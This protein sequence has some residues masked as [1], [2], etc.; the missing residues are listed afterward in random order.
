[1]NINLFR[2]LIPVPDIHEATS[3]YQKLFRQE[4]ERVAEGRHYFRL[5]QLVIALLDPKS[6]GRDATHVPNPEF[7]YFEVDDLNGMHHHVQQLPFHHVDPQ[8]RTR[9][10]GETSFYTIDPWKNKLC[11]VQSGTCFFGGRYVE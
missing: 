5:G 3:F 11:F 10:W 4:G 2:V 6:D 7:L 1:M 8:I 9:P